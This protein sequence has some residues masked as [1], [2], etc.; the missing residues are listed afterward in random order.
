MFDSSSEKRRATRYKTLKGARITFNNGRSTI[1]CTVRN[2]SSTGARLQVT[3][4]VGVPNAFILRMGEAEPK[5]CR[6]MW[7]AL[8]E[9]GVQF[10]SR[11][12]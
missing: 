7:R 9:L 4:V 3:S 8:K 6:V 10:E 5:Y 11:Y 1:D 2:L 12:A